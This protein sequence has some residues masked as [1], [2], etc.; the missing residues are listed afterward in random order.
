MTNIHQIQWAVVGATGNV[1]QEFLKIL[2]EKGVSSSHVVALASEKSQGQSLPYGSDSLIVQPLSAY[3]FTQCDVALFSAGAS[4]S[5]IYAPQAEAQ[6]CWVIDNTSFFRMHS[7]IALVVPEINASSI[8]STTRRIIA[9][10]NCSTIQMLMALAPIHALA[11]LKRVIVSTYQSVSGAGRSAINELATQTQA[12]LQG[13]PLPPA[14]RFSRPIAGNVIP[15]IDVFL[16][17]ASTKE[18]WKMVVETQKILCPN[19]PVAATCVRVP[20][21]RGHSESIYFE[22]E[23]DPSL[24]ELEQA[25]RSFPG[26]V[27]QNSPDAFLTPLEA[28]Y[29]DAT[30]V[31]RL[32]RD[33][34]VPNAYQMWVVADNI[35]KGA[36]LNAIQIAQ[37]LA[38][39]DLLTPCA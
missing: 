31:S 4:V 9:N 34:L 28:A 21:A 12:S 29:R 23:S 5:S 30:F 10:P 18:E 35:R 26:V 6:G 38:D 11:S 7:D 39:E 25:L 15:Q 20:V 1:G 37:W 24:E 3:N 8:R 32:R 14:V 17:D 2:Q 33:P 27:L 16:P 13:Q 22:L 36:A 19:L